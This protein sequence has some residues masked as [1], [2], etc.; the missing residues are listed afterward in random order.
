V[1]TSAALAPFRVAQPARPEGDPKPLPYLWNEADQAHGAYA[2]EMEVLISTAKMRAA[3]HA[4]QRLSKGPMSAMY[5]TA[6]QLIAHH[7]ANGCNLRPGDLLGTGT[8]S[9]ES[10]ETFGSLLELSEGGKRPIELP[11]GETRTFLEDGDEIVMKA[12]AVR[13]GYRTIGFGECRAMIRG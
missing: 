13:E 1:V 10:R 9:S 7:T 2:I 3:G 12:H 4:P 8:L 11:G 6:G 5:W